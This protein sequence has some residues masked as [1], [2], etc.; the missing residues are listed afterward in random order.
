[1]NKPKVA[2]IILNWNG[3]KDTI[4]CLESVYQTEYSNY[5]VILV[6]NNSQDDSIQKIRDYCDGKIEVESDFFN[7]SSKNKPIECVEYTEKET[8][9]DREE[10]HSRVLFNR[11]LVLIKN[12]KNHGFAEGN[13][14]AIRH[15]LGVSNPDYIL[16]LNN[17]V[18]TDKDFLNNLVDSAEKEESI[19]ITGPKIYYY[20]YGSKTDIINFTGADIILWRGS[21]IRYGSNQPDG[22]EWNH[23]RTVDKLEGSCMLIKRRVFEKIG[24]LDAKYFAYWEDTDFCMRAK[25]NGFRSIYVPDSKVWHKGSSSSKRKSGVYEYYMTRNMFWFIRKNATPY[26]FFL[27]LMY[28]FLFRFWITAGIQVLYHRDMAEFIL[29]L[30]GISEGMHSRC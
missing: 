12:E 17:D 3:W 7:Y 6:D 28:F 30:R 20:S 4:E 14:I 18:V 10:R 23:A 16:L 13:N 21:E 11:R 15:V 26:E 2:I 8:V 1:M 22:E 27:F 9:G 19:G 5:E 24:L 29:Y 25:K